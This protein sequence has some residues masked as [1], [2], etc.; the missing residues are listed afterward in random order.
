MAKVELRLCVTDPSICASI[1]LLALSIKYYTMLETLLQDIE[2]TCFY[3][4]PDQ[5]QVSASGQLEDSECSGWPNPQGLEHRH[6]GKNRHASSPFRRS[7]VSAVQQQQ[8]RLGIV[9]QDRQ[10]MGLQRGMIRWVRSLW[11]LVHYS[12]PFIHLYTC[13]GVVFW[14]CMLVWKY[15]WHIYIYHSLWI[16]F[17][18]YVSA[19]YRKNTS[20]RS[21]RI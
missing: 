4:L 20:Q 11:A 6:Q 9:R 2:N 15:V 3:L 8:D 17:Y 14:V 16:H 5:H 10:A 13:V 18:N 7:H 12:S 1:K 21:Q 19:V